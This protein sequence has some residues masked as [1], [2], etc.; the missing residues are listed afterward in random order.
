MKYD[1]LRAVQSIITPNRCPFCGVLLTEFEYWHEDCALALPLCKIKRETPTGLTKYFAVCTYEGAARRAVLELKNGM[2]YA[3]DAMAL[4]MTEKIGGREYA[5]GAVFVPVPSNHKSKL[6]RGYQP[7][8]SL[9]LYMARC[10][11]IPVVAALKAA[12]KKSTQKHLGIAKRKKNAQYSFL[13]TRAIKRI[14][15]KRVILVDDICT[16]GSTLSACAEC[17]WQAGAADV[18]GVTFAQ[19]VHKE[20]TEPMIS[21]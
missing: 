21:E 6:F 20:R 8:K 5:A 17:M 9:A 10:C 2:K 14:S 18:V 7:A 1:I 3:A 19:T 4:L 13:K 12:N 16:T 15:G 11:R